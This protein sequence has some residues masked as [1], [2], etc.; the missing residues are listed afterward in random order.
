MS[1]EKKEYDNKPLVFKVLK[2]TGKT[3]KKETDDWKLFTLFFESEKEFPL[4]L[5]AFGNL[6]TKEKA[7]SVTLKDLEE[8]SVYTVGWKES[9]YIHKEHGAQ[10]NRTVTWMK[11]SEEEP[12]HD[13][14]PIPVAGDL[15]VTK[16]NEPFIPPSVKDIMQDLEI[17]KTKLTEKDI[18]ICCPGKIFMVWVKKMNKDKKGIY[19]NKQ[20]LDDFQGQY[21]I[22]FKE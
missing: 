17:I 16:A 7:T 11:V 22:V 8:G 19:I 15:P 1:E 2:Y 5:S 14:K 9:E 4:K 10:I 6:G 20:T 13:L 3:L 18:T 12:C 21:D